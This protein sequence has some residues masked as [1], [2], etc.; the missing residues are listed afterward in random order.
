MRNFAG[1]LRGFAG[2]GTNSQGIRLDRTATGSV[3]LVLADRYGHILRDKQE[4]K[5]RCRY[6][7]I[8]LL[9]TWMHS[10]ATVT[11]QPAIVCRNWEK[12]RVRMVRVAMTTSYSP[13][14]FT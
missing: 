14:F 6:K 3:R 12:M 1:A 9:H 8:R 13:P 4:S 11:W 7:T 5:I 10:N 2:V